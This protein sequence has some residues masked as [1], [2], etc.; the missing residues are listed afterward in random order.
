M[1]G[2]AVYR[3]PTLAFAAFSAT[4]GLV[5]RHLDAANLVDWATIDRLNNAQIV[6]T[7]EHLTIFH[8]VHEQVQLAFEQIGQR[9][10]TFGLIHADL[11]WKNYFFHADGVG[12]LDF[13]S[14]GWGYYLYDLA[15]TLLGYRDEP[16]YPAFR[17]A[18]LAGYRTVRPLLSQDEH[19]LNACIAARHLVSCSWL[20]NR[21]D[22]PDLRTR[23][24]AIVAERTAEMQRL[25]AID[26]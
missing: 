19:H 17:E 13:D 10:T 1:A 16:D 2:R 26:R 8:A 18:L 5:R 15:P 20:A 21:L 3:H 22:H 6:F 12:A 23:A 9:A 11:I 24:D 4:S 14:C 25:I 7:D